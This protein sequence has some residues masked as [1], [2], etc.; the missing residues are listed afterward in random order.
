M[1]IKY[2]KKIH[3]EKSNRSDA[4][5]YRSGNML[6]LAWL[7]FKNIILHKEP[8]KTEGLPGLF[9]VILNSSDHIVWKGFVFPKALLF[10]QLK[11][12]VL[13][14]ELAHCKSQEGL[15]R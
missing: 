14:G 2:I 7:Y 6:L 3:Q 9:S 12:R 1:I 10:S 5:C 11:L 8:V 4:R 13:L 15:S